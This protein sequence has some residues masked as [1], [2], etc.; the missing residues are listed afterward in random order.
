MAR[1]VIVSNRVPDPSERTGPRAGGLVVGLAEALVPGTLWFGWSGR[2]AETTS[3]T[4]K[5]TETPDLTYATI[6]L[7]EADYRAFYLGFANSTLWP[8]FHM[9]PSLAVFDRADYAI[10]RRV[11]DAF[12]EALLTLLRPDDLIWVHDYQLIGVAA[13]LRARGV[14][15]RIGFFLHIPFP[16]PAVLDILP[17]ARELLASLLAYDVI[18]LQ[19]NR[20][21][22]LFADAVHA[23]FGYQM[24]P[25]HRITHQGHSAQI[26]VAPVG[27]DAQAF[28]AMAVRASQRVETRRMIDSLAGRALMI[29]V[30]RLDYT[31]GLPARF[32]AYE[33][34]LSRYAEHRRKLSF[35][36]IAAP[37]REEVERYRALRE[38]LDHKT[39]SI[40]GAFSDF[41][42]VP[43]RYMTRTLGRTLIAGFYR[44]ARIGLV[45]PLRDGM[46][47]VA[48]EYIAAQN[49]LDPGVL[50][51]SIFAGAAEGLPEAL[52]VNP[53][54]ID[55]VAEAVH[56]ALVMPVDERIERHA[57]L[58][59]H[60]TAESAQVYCQRF[61]AA[62]TRVTH[63][64]L[65]PRA[66]SGKNAA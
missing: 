55:A 57:A 37:S 49:P 6:D 39:G 41:D 27:I 54:D 32:E 16:A 19:T 45:T 51:L 62:L 38:E 58:L 10:Y 34:F 66:T 9:M 60:V 20:D 64:T 59:G 8:L 13:S 18:G 50:I 43:L 33:R 7:G 14:A 31:K 35:L 63:P 4:A 40:N 52:L 5:M 36:Q 46:N 24:T 47:L 42:W 22:T 30:D 53:F 65:V 2:R 28:N 3:T 23:A 12:A 44:T 61:V 48:K 56:A 1:L 17:P 25:D 11:N 21:R 15:N 26:I 29:G